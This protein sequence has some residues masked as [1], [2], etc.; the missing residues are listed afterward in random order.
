MGFRDELRFVLGCSDKTDPGYEENKS[1]NAIDDQC[2]DIGRI[3]GSID[4]Q[5]GSIDQT[6]RT[7]ESEQSSKDS[8]EIHKRII[9]E[10]CDN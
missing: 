1:Q 6:A 2:L 8:F 9:L 10:K 3:A 5:N 4:E 7:K